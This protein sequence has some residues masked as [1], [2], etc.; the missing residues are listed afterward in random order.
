MASCQIVMLRGTLVSNS[1][2]FPLKDE[3]R[4]ALHHANRPRFLQ[5]LPI[6]ATMI[7]NCHGKTLALL[8]RTLMPVGT[9]TENRSPV[10]GSR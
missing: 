6:T 9:P 7:T 2:L 3:S 5:V 4:R 10:A 1:Y 8:M